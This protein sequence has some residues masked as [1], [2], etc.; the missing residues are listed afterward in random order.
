MRPNSF[1]ELNATVERLRADGDRSGALELLTRSEAFFPPQAALTRMLRVE[2]LA[3][4]GRTDAAVDLLRDGLDRGYRY[5]GRWLR[6]ERFVALTSHP[7]FSALVERSDTQYETAQAE[8]RPDL[9]ILVPREGPGRE[10]RVLIALHGNNRT[11]RDTVPSWQSVVREGWVLAVPQSSE[12]GTTPGFFIWNDRERARKDIETHLETLSSRLSPDSSRF[13]LGGF[14][15]GAR[16]ALELGLSGSSPARK[17]L[18]I[19][20]WLPDFET[21]ANLLEA[22]VIQKSL[23][24]VVVGRHDASGYEGSVRLV[25]HLRTLGAHAEL[26]IHEGGHEEPGDMPATLHRALAFLGGDAP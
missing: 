22:S 7:D 11:M 1:N 14:S 4:M 12:I 16:L 25:D 13:V 24:Y 21:L 20:T 19:A 23:V 10:E 8:A 3:A 26:E 15:M 18:A 9:S 2:L 17:I 6:H 5:R